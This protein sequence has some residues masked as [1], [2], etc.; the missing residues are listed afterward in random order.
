MANVISSIGILDINYSSISL[1]DQLG[2]DY[3]NEV[4]YYLNDFSGTNFNEWT[5]KALMDKIKED[6]NLLLSYNPKLIIITGIEYIEY[7][8]EYFDSINIPTIN[9][10]DCVINNI[11]NDYAKKN[12]SLLIKSTIH[13]TNL[14]QRELNYGHYYVVNDDDL[15]R[16]VLFD[17]V[18]T[19]VSFDV[20]KK[21]LADLNRKSVDLIVPTICNA[22]LLS[23]EF[24]EYLPKT[25]ILNTT[26]L[27]SKMVGKALSDNDLSKLKGKGEINI[28][29]SS[30]DDLTQIKCLLK[31]K[32]CIKLKKENDKKTRIWK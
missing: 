32:Y 12:I 3:P 8:K 28:I 13:Q 4:F 26:V 6:V 27:L 19:E 10:V 30:N 24:K 23:T 9:I 22:S 7:A 25:A 1:L 18:K 14:Y 29:A 21:A 11:N 16:L 17:K 5:H 2:Q 20:V 15:S 31:S